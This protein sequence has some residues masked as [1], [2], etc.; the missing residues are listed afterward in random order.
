MAVRVHGR[1][2]QG[3][4]GRMTLAIAHRGDPLR[5]RENT[6]PSLRSAVAEGADWIEVDVKLTR[7]AVPVLLH[8]DTLQRLWGH[9]RRV[10]ALTRA[11]LDA[12][13][14]T[15]PYRIPDLA[16]ALRLGRD[17][18]VPLMLDTVRPAE[19]LAALEL[20]RTL[21]CLA[22]T[23]FTG[24]PEAMAAVRAA[25]PTAVIAM[26]WESPLPP[27]P[28][29]LR[30][31]R[32]EYVNPYYRWLGPGRIARLHARGVKV[33]TWTV[34]RAPT[35][36]ALAAAG[37]DAI[38]SNDVRTLRRVLGRA[39]AGRPAAEHGAGTGVTAGPSAGLDP[40]DGA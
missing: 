21:G 11:E 5:F 26:S 6:L 32:P 38:I 29:L 12:L 20:A 39:D 37:A 34:D 25:A 17:S 7:D 14:R 10:G 31:V 2:S 28:G 9:D 19:G 40:V 35:M 3:A 30:L 23:V 18:G 27:R 24:P 13:T 36:A 1:R 4:G 16:E 33:S 15:D 8:D 22:G